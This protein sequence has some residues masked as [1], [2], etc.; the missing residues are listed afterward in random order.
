MPLL[1]TLVLTTGLLAF[2]PTSVPL[3]TFEVASVKHAGA[4]TE[5]NPKYVPMFEARTGHFAF[6]DTLLTLFR[7]A[8]SLPP[9][10]FSAPDWMKDQRYEIKARAAARTSQPD[11]L[12]MTRRLLEERFGLRYH[13][14]DQPLNVY[15]LMPGKG[16]EGLVAAK[17]GAARNYSYTLGHFRGTATLDDFAKA[18]GIL[19]ERT[20]INRT[21]YDGLYVFNVSWNQ[22]IPG[23]R[24]NARTRSQNPGEMVTTYLHVAERLG[25]KLQPGKATVPVL[26]ID[27]INRDPTPN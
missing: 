4:L 16:K 7:A 26:V 21:G 3:P 18:L 13:Y 17:R 27:S 20:T 9:G 10:A 19:L 25:L 8:F 23:Y 2:Q 6:N 12:L 22:D 1:S 11:S 14:E 15:E 24:T 5:L